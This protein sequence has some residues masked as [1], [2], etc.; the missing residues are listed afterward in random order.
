MAAA[1]TPPDLSG[2]SE[3]ETQDWLKIST[4]TIGALGFAISV[5]QAGL[6]YMRAYHAHGV[7]DRLGTLLLVPGFYSLLVACFPYIRTET[8][9]VLWQSLYA[10]TW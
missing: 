9:R 3:A 2:C 10:C 8:T 7:K 1:H 5:A 6:I 4:A